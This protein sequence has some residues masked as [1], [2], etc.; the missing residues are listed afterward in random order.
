MAAD[1]PA[2]VPSNPFYFNGSMSEAVLKTYMSRAVSFEGFCAEGTMDNDLLFD[3]SMRMITRT[4]AKFISRAAIFGWTCTNNDMM[5]KHFALAEKNAK[6]AHAID[7][8]LILQGFVSECLYKK[9]ADNTPIPAWVFEAFGDPVEKRNFNWENIVQDNREG[10]GRDFWCKE[11]GYP[12]WSKKEC[13]CWYYYCIRSYIDIGLES[14]HIQEADQ[15]SDYEYECEVSSKVLNMARQYAKAKARRGIV[16]FHNFLSMKKGGSKVGNKLIF[17]IN[18]GGLTPNETVAEGGVLKCILADPFQD[19]GKYWSTWFGRSVGGE[20]PLGFATDVCPTMLELDN[21]GG[22]F[23]EYGKSNGTDFGTW[24]YDD[25]TWF[26]LQPEWYRNK[27][28][29]YLEE[30]TASYNKKTDNTPSSGGRAYYI[31]YPMRRLLHPTIP[32]SPTCIYTPGNMFSRE[33]LFAL[34]AIPGDTIRIKTNSNNTFELT[35]VSYYR[36]NRQSDGCPN[37]FNQED[38]IRQIF[39]GKN[40]PD[41]L[42]DKV[43]LPTGYK[44]IASSGTPPSERK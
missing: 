36:A 26:A 31:V 21:Y 32:K 37:G 23:G 40:V 28:L 7:P 33:F 24:G 12:D 3:E 16:L 10:K 44:P 2:P 39:L 1:A 29:L 35:T 15:E 9:L 8:E 34:A 22:P 41:N 25:Q 20:H 18:G 14:I 30:R 17:D 38:T 43:L 42:K 11:A 19:G 27:F 4:G 6:K 13:Q 5:E